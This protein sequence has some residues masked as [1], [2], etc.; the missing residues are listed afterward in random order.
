[1]GQPP[2]EV[3]GSDFSRRMVNASDIARLAYCERQIRF[4][5]IRGRR[6][7]AVQG[8][9]RRR[10]RAAHQVFYEESQRL[11]ERSDR[12]GRCFV[13]TMALGDAPDTLALRQFR[14][15]YLRRS[16]WGRTL[17][18]AYYRYSPTVCVALA[19]RPGLLKLTRGALRLL[20]RAAAIAVRRSLQKNKGHDT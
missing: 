16:A 2:K 14:D 9:A 4:D 19:D 12:R 3:R 10:G 11:A 7:S 20:A 15:L 18:A 13:A 8:A 5:A 1:M 6:T 17:I